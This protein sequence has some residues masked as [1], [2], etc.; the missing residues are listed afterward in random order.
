MQKSNGSNDRAN[1]YASEHYYDGSTGMNIG[2]S[3][4]RNNL[5][6]AMDFIAGPS[7]P[8]IVSEDMTFENTSVLVDTNKMNT[9][10][11]HMT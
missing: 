4:P 5:A 2:K 6:K 3:S 8:S 10:N 7:G 1:D 11:N 9:R